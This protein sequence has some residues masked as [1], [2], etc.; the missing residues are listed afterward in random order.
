MCCQ[1]RWVFNV[2]YFRLHYIVLW[3][4]PKKIAGK[5]SGA[6]KW[7]DT[8]GGKGVFFPLKL[9][10]LTEL[11][12]LCHWTV[13]RWLFLKTKIWCIIHFSLKLEVKWIFIPF[14]FF[15][16]LLWK[17]KCGQSSSVKL[18]QVYGV[19][20]WCLSEIIFHK[21]ECFLSLLQGFVEKKDIIVF[22]HSNLN[23]KLSGK[24]LWI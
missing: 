21:G 14:F 19:N 22:I 15:F 9:S 18:Y 16:A 17:K 1:Q 11:T 13:T 2:W 6:F 23:V 24:K 20:E 8:Q 5:K 4:I 12:S 7:N 10:L 3:S